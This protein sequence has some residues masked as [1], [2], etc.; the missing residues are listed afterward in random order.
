MIGLHWRGIFPESLEH[1]TEFGFKSTDFERN[2][3]AR[4]YLPSLLNKPDVGQ[5]VQIMPVRS[6]PDRKP[7]RLQ[8]AVI[9][10]LCDAELG[11]VLS[12]SWYAA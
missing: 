8:F 9:S 4:E 11:E 2:K 12:A 10:C 6:L 1:N 7:S 5:L 3:S